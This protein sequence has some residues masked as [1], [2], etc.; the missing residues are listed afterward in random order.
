ME[1]AMLIR[2]IVTFLVVLAALDV[3]ATIASLSTLPMD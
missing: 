3:F 2:V 1:A